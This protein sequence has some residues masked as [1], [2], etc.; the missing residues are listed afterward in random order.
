M[1]SFILL[2]LLLATVACSPRPAAT[3]PSQPAPTLSSLPSVTAADAA[4]PTVAPTPIPPATATSLSAATATPEPAAS[5]TTL[6]EPAT[7]LSASQA[8]TARL[9]VDEIPP[10]RDD[11]ALAVAYRG[12]DPAATPPSAA[13]LE[14]GATEMFYIGNVDSN[15]VSQIEAQLLSVG[16]NAYFWFDLG[17]GSV[18]PDPALLAESTEAFDAIYDQLFAYFGVTEPPGGRVH[19]VHASPEALC[20]EANQCRL[21]GY[22]S[23]R[24]LLPVSVNPQSNQR[25]MFV[26]NAWQF[27]GGTYLDVLAHELRHML[28]DSYDSGEEDWFVEGGAMLAED[29][30]G[31]STVPQARGSLFLQ[32]PDQQLNS[33]TN[34]NTIPHYG[35]GYLL[36]RYLYDRLGE[37]A[38]HDFVTDTRPGLSAVDAVA[39]ANGLNATGEQ[40]WLDW[41]AAMAIQGGAETA[42]AYRWLGPEL[43]PVLTTPI[44]SLPSDFDTAVEQ[45]AADYYELPSSGTVQLAFS[46]MPAVSLLGADAPSGEN[47][48]YAQRANY[49]NPRLT[50]VVDLS[51]VASAALQ[52]NAYV[53]IEHGYDFAYV[54]ASTDGGQTWQA[55]TADGMQGLD[56]AD[57]PSGSALADRFYTGRQQAWHAQ[58]ID[59]TPFAGQEI[60]LRFEYVTDPILTFGGFAL[61]DIAIPEIGFAD[62]AETDVDGWSAEGFARATDSLLQAWRLQLITF[63][64][65]GQPAVQGL[66]VGDDGQL[67]TTYQAMPGVRR[68]ILIVASAVPETLQPMAYTLAVSAPQTAGVMR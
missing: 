41:L 14:S 39:A 11:V 59:L 29:L 53:D 61:D 12:A 5:A 9:L 17:S 67:M 30:T 63:D 8:A 2:L 45:F 38:Y 55:L 32:D 18:T 27:G 4:S 19:I 20:D 37:T 49:S 40:L 46:G 16:E 54:A 42:E 10:V 47:F 13:E 28:G 36:Q 34:E 23:S 66:A 21:A 48:W 60:L 6:V 50:R 65:D 52:Y 31:F 26:M 56:P 51:D 58:S 68:P 7:D 57:D 24:D 33:W 62:D 43:E 3:P 44:D 25:A 64:A 1:R 15:T 22:F 35:Q